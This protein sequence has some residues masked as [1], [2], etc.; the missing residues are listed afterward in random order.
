MAKENVPAPSSRRT[1]CHSEAVVIGPS[2]YL[3][4]DA[5]STSIQIFIGLP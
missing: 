1:F 2:P 4:P 3:T 5:F